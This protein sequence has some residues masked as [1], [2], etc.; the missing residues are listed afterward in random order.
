MIR[1]RKNTIDVNPIQDYDDLLKIQLSNGNW[2]ADP[3]MHGMA[4]GM[5]LFHSMAV[6]HTVTPDFK[7]APQCWVSK[8]AQTIRK[9]K[10]LPKK[11]WLYFQWVMASIISSIT[12]LEFEFK[13][14]SSLIT[15]QEH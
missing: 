13:D 8:F 12:G 4:N 6:N 3:Y 14:V 15:Y 2:D 9:L 10:R 11:L 7:T 5:I 1:K